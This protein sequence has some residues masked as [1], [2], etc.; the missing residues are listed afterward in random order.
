M[1]ELNFDAGDR[2]RFRLAL[3]EIE[4]NVL[5]SSDPSVVL[6]KFD[7]GYN[8]GLSK[9]NILGFKVIKKYKNEEKEKI[10]LPIKKELKNIGMIITGGTIASK[11]DAKTGG[12]KSMAGIS[13]FYHYYPEMFNI[14]NIS[15]I[16]IP[17]LI[18]SESMNSEHWI[19]IAEK[20]KEMLD[21]KNIEG[22]VITHG[23]DTLHYTAYA[24]S[25]FLRELSKP[26][27]LTFS[28]RSIDRASSDANLNLQC[29]VRMALSDSSG[30]FIVGHSSMSDDFCFAIRGTKARKLHTSRRDA[31][32]PVND[33]P[34][35][36][37]WPDRVEFVGKYKSRNEEKVKL[38]LEFSDKV[39]LVKVYPGQ[40][41]SILDFYA[42]KYK[43]IIIEGTGFG[44]LPTSEQNNWLPRLKKHIKNG[45]VVCMTSQC[46]FGR[47]NPYVYSPARE[48]LDAGVVYLEDMLS[49]TAFVK[50]SWV[51]GHYGWKAHV[52]EKMLENL[53]G[54]MNETDAV[55]E[56]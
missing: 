20:A 28:Q 32:K 30:V 51:L 37:V 31:F 52:K 27:V 46:I 1:V 56:I 39:A 40:D 50:L 22:V 8:I 49:E 45:L 6:I 14:A 36:K 55:Q 21:D 35:A 48:L 16:E 3:D 44:H 10:D 18:A 43:G 26:V 7:S 34:V 33:I 19:K 23:T 9:E 2:V 42:L 25:F 13:E 54:E 15:K 41:P 24:L 12:A 17:F 29:A 38:D 5:E 47:V 4:G 53:A 11:Y